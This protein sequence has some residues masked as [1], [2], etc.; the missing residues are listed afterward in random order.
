M[1]TR[2]SSYVFVCA[3]G[4]EKFFHFTECHSTILCQDLSDD[5]SWLMIVQLIPRHRNVGF[6]KIP[7][8]NRGDGLPDLPGPVD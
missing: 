1:K 6:V 2:M 8:E 3:R 4:E 7:F 5:S